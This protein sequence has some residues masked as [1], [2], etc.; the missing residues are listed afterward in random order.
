MRALNSSCIFGGHPRLQRLRR[1]IH[2]R[3][4][5]ASNGNYKRTVEAG[6]YVMLNKLV[7]NYS[8]AVARRVRSSD[9]NDATAGAE[10][11]VVPGPGC[12][13]LLGRLQQA[14]HL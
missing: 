11:A 13:P 7:I 12:C 8:S 4:T 3:R 2:A 5:L 9:A 1:R 10:T 14:Q 6:A